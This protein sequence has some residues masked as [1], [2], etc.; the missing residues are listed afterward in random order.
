VCVALFV[1][2]ID[3]VDEMKRVIMDS[4]QF[5]LTPD[6]SLYSYSDAGLIFDVVCLS[7]YHQ[8][9]CGRTGTSTF[10]G[11]LNFCS[12]NVTNNND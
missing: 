4:A 7:Y 11:L 2:L 12:I 5:L 6:K 10:D 1:R 9:L 8:P 3:A